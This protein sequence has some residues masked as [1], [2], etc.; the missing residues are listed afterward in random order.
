MRLRQQRKERRHERFTRSAI[1]A[2]MRLAF[3]AFAAW[4]AYCGWLFMLSSSW[5][6]LI[7]VALS[8]TCILGAAKKERN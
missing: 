2:H 8:A 7:L 4:M 6:S 3:I 5:P 1:D